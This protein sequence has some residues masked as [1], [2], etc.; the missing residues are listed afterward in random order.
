MTVSGRKV[1]ARVNFLRLL[2]GRMSSFAS[3]PILPFT[4]HVTA[5]PDRWHAVLHASTAY[6][7]LCLKLACPLALCD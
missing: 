5:T 7:V 6:E 4:P 2:T 1:W 3:H